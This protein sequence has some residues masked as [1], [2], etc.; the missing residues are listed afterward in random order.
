VTAHSLGSFPGN[1][2]TVWQE[3]WLHSQEP[4][5]KQAR[6]AVVHCCLTGL[7][8]LKQP[9]LSLAI[10]NCLLVPVCIKGPVV[11]WVHLWAKFSRG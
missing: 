3:D 1:E 5:T 2:N 4:H 6:F 11:P 7:T 10:L 9:V 8:C